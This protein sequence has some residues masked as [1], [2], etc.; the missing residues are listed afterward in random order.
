M[1][2]EEQVKLH[3]IEIR[4]E[5]WEMAS[6][7]MLTLMEDLKEHSNTK[8]PGDQIYCLAYLM[9]YLNAKIFKAVEG[10]ANTYAIE[11]LTAEDMKRWTEQV[12]K[13]ILD[14]FNKGN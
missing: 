2:G 5:A 9:G 1:E 11:K 6:K 14:L 8:D 12:T 13:E 10:Y 4:K 3:Y 7:I